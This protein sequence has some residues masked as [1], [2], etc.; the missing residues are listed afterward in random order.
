MSI[1]SLEKSFVALP[2]GSHRMFRPPIMKWTWWEIP[3]LCVEYP[4]HQGGPTA[5]DLQ[6]EFLHAGSFRQ[7]S[8]TVFRPTVAGS[9]A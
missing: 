6:R 4:I 2:S 1:T 9:V 8:S 7:G 3:P 5:D